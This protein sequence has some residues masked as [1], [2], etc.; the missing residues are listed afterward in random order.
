[1]SD[2][3]PEELLQQLLN[4]QPIDP[5]LVAA[6]REACLDYFHQAVHNP[7]SVAAWSE[8]WSQFEEQ[9]A[10]AFPL[11]DYVRLKHRRLKGARQILQLSGK[12]DK[13]Y[14]PPADALATHCPDCGE[15]SIAEEQQYSCPR[16]KL[17]LAIEPP[18]A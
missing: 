7:L 13:E 10:R 3:T 17:A 18:T 8:W 12:L 11:V 6:D 4:P 9:A 5:A 14:L 16:C 2:P 15:R 1:M